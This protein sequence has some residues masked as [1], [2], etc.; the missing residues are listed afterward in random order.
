MSAIEPTRTVGELVA[1]DPRRARVL[2]AVGIDYC[3]GGKTPL[4]SACRERGLD[5]E[6]VAQQLAMVAEDADH[7]GEDCASMSLTA[8]ADHIEASHHA[9]LRVE[10]PRLERLAARVAEAHG[11]RD[12]RLAE[13]STVLAAFSAE[14]QHHMT[15]EERMLFP[16]IRA[17]E[18]GQRPR[19]YHFGSIANPI[20]IMESEHDNS[21]DALAQ[22]RELTNGFDTSSAQC[23]THLALLDG[24]A[25]LESDTHRHVHKE[26]SILFPRAIE[27]EAAFDARKD[28]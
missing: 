4:E 13:L 20:R 2:E 3:C 12:I 11:Q 16:I 5:P 27:L 21:G 1:D 15:K 10:L 18:A 22:M 7:A 9:Y 28:A 14:M 8:L 25:T 23:N 17:L 19:A 26:N 6:Q 24:L